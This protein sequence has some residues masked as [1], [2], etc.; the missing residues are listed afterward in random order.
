MSLKIKLVLATLFLAIFAACAKPEPTPDPDV[1][2]AAADD[3][4]RTVRLND[5]TTGVEITCVIWE[6]NETSNGHVGA[7]WCRQL[8]PAQ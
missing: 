5:D 4:F 8:N 6:K 7:M 2:G 3:Y 1:S